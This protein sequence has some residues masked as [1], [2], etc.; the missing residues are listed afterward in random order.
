MN[1]LEELVQSLV[2]AGLRLQHP[3]AFPLR[4]LIGH[5]LNRPTDC[6]LGSD[7]GKK[8]I[9]HKEA[10]KAQAMLNRAFLRVDFQLCYRNLQCVYNYFFCLPRH[11]VSPQLPLNKKPTT[12]RHKKHV[13]SRRRSGAVGR[14]FCAEKLRVN[15]SLPWLVI[16]RF[17][18]RRLI[19][20]VAMDAEV[21][22]KPKVASSPET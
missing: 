21:K 20:R 18:G 11:S 9:S 1:V 10:Q 3:P 7:R 16:W 6:G 2:A 17:R 4:R 13:R 22:A 12:N 19:V 8:F 14:F 15:H 5:A